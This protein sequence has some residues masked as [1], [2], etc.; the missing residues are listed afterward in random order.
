L[1]QFTGL[2]D[3]NGKEIYEGNLYVFQIG[4]ATP[5]KPKYSLTA[6]L[7]KG[8]EMFGAWQLKEKA[9]RRSIYLVESPLAVMKFHQ[10]GVP[11]VSPF[12]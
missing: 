2:H 11:A 12:G 1:V 8:L 7:H 6:G 4:E 5:E 9:P 3:K 10:M